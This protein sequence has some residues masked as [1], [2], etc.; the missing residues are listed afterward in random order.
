MDKNILSIII[1][2]AIVAIIACII[3]SIV[4]CLVRFFTKSHK[5]TKQFD[6]EMMGADSNKGPGETVIMVEDNQQAAKRAFQESG[7]ALW[8]NKGK[9]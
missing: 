1:A 3:S 6:I 8:T 9:V 5:K 7:N 4:Y 2:M